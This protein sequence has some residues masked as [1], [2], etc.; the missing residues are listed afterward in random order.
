[1]D[2]VSCSTNP[3][4]NQS[5]YLGRV[6]P[7][8]HHNGYVVFL[9]SEILVNADYHGGF[10]TRLCCSGRL[11]SEQFDGKGTTCSL[12]RMRRFFSSFYKPAWPEI[13]LIHFYEF[14]K[15]LFYGIGQIADPLAKEAKNSAPRCQ[16]FLLYSNT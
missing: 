8:P 12:A 14:G 2:S 5:S 16:N 7:A 9:M 1:M 4:L 11:S 3:F 15:G 13:V 6:D 10:I